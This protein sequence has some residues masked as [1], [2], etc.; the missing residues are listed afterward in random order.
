MNIETKRIGGIWHGCLE[1][2]PE[3]DESG[4]TEE[5]ARKKVERIV[6]KMDEEG[7][8]GSQILNARG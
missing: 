6:E 3:V 8:R 4:L 2:H 5:V 7:R 1:G